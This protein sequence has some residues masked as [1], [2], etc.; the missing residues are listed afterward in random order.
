[1]GKLFRRVYT[2]FVLH[3]Y[4]KKTTITVSQ[5]TAQ[6]LYKL[7]FTDVHVFPNTT[8]YPHI[9]TPTPKIKLV[10][11]SVGRIVPNKQFSHAIHILK[12]LHNK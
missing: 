10:L 5:A 9:Q 1:M 2:Y 6:E 8:D 11:T 12:T 4:R 7:G 3:L